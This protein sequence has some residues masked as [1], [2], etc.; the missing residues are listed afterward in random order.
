MLGN[1]YEFHLFIS[2]RVKKSQ[3]EDCFMK[4]TQNALEDIRS[5]PTRGERRVWRLNRG[6]GRK[7]GLTVYKLHI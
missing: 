5:M 3:I 1:K 6:G 4:S 2:F 7:R